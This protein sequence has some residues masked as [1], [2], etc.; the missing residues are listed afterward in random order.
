MLVCSSVFIVIIIIIFIIISCLRKTSRG[1]TNA[2][3]VMTPKSCCAP[4]GEFPN[5]INTTS[6]IRVNALKGPHPTDGRSL[7]ENKKMNNL[8]S[9]KLH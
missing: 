2:D 5:A 1:S 7:Q 3:D 8:N 9:R 6:Q 4:D